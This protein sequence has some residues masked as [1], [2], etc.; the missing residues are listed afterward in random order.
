MSENAT[1]VI[2]SK[3]LC[4]PPSVI[5]DSLRSS[6]YSC[7]SRRIGKSTHLSNSCNAAQFSAGSNPRPE[8]KRFRPES[9]IPM[10]YLGSGENESHFYMANKLARKYGLSSHFRSHLR[11]CT[12][13]LCQCKMAFASEL[14]CVYR[15]DL[16]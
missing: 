2:L 6:L 10:L 3:E 1:L 15:S 9:L 14:I 5:P 4:L 11:G 16:S 7:S 12:C 13:M 8:Y